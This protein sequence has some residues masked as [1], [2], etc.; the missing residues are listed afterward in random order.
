MRDATLEYRLS[1][2]HAKPSDTG[3]YTCNTPNNKSHAVEIVVQDTRCPII[4][5]TPGLVADTNQ[6]EIGSRVGFSCDNGAHLV[7][8]ARLECL[9]TGQWDS[10]TPACEDVICPDIN[11]IVQDRLILKTFCMTTFRFVCS[12]GLMLILSQPKPY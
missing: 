11:T 2:Y 6:T 7:G 5:L 12:L 1:I 8:S 4:S 9:H 10:L 3:L